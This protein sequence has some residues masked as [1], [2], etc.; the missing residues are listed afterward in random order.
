MAIGSG[1]F[2]NAANVAAERALDDGITLD[3]AVDTFR[4]LWVRGALIRN[5]GNQCRVASVAGMHRNTLG[6]M[7]KRVGIGLPIGPE[8]RRPHWGSGKG[9]DGG[10]AAA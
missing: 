5:K 1:N 8:L 3:E 7:I 2:L 4:L 6:R 10:K 9:R